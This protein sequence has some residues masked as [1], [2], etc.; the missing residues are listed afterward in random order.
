[1]AKILEAA[2]IGCSL[3][4]RFPLRLLIIFH[5][6]FKNAITNLLA[7]SLHSLQLLSSNALLLNSKALSAGATSGL[8]KVLKELSR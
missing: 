3:N 6:L 4:S 2:F 8:R 7:N 5:L 1:V